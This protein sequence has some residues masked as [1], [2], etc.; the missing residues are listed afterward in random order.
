MTNWKTTA[1]GLLTL[2]A[3]LAPI[4]A[5]PELAR[6]LEMTAGVLAASGLVAAKDA[7]R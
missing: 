5:T 6:K 7:N 1:A 2:A 4:W 3:A